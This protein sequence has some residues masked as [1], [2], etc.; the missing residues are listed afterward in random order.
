M[1][2]KGAAVQTAGGGYT[3]QEIES[4]STQELLQAYKRTGDEELKWPLVLRYEGLIKTAALQVR[5]VYSSFAQV[6]DIVNEGIL[7][8]LNCID[9]FDPDKGIKFETY[10][11]KRIRGMVIDLARKQDWLPRNVRQRAKEI[12]QAVSELSNQLGR[13]PTDA[14]VAQYMGVTLEKYQKDAAKVALDNTLSLDAL[15]E[16]RDPEGY[17]FEA[18]AED[19]HGQPEAALQ[20]RELQQVL[21]KGI[22]AL[23]ENEQI[24][25]SLY[26]EKNLHMKEIAKVMEVSEP[27]ISQI[28]ARAIQKLR[29][30][31]NGYMN[32][33]PAPKHS[34][35]RKKG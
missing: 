11:S 10:V 5:G 32:G 6:G 9:K 24:V 18:A 22:G 19:T 27:R 2:E 25:L 17:R 30:Y 29:E 13:F 8:L 16:A 35:K 20:E 31:M 34:K 26:Y 33:V 12:D 7:T 28:H 14:E 3:A 15:M 23:Q 4:L 1:T 21:A